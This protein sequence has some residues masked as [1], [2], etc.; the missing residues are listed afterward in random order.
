MY[1]YRWCL[2]ER[3]V[4]NNYSDQNLINNIYE[5][6][7]ELGWCAFRGLSSAGQCLHQAKPFPP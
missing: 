2:L 1:D 7:A 4:E 5:D 6:K 3:G